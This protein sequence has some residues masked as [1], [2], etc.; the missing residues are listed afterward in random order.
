MVPAQETTL[1]SHL[2]SQVLARCMCLQ[3]LSRRLLLQD[4]ARA[5]CKIFQ[6]LARP[7]ICKIAQEDLANT[8]KTHVWQDRARQST[9]YWQDLAR[10]SKI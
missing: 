7:I 5:S 4:R 3:D 1:A 2:V 9:I 8:C 10:L 6:V